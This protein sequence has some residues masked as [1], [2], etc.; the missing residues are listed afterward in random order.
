M[1]RPA[2]VQAAA[3][4]HPSVLEFARALARAHVVRD[5]AKFGAARHRQD[6]ATGGDPGYHAH[7]DLRPI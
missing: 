3:P 6:A 1:T 5:I 4:S 2:R 7:T